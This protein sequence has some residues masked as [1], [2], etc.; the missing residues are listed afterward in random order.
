ME[1]PFKDIKAGEMTQ[2]PN[3]AWP[4]G[5]MRSRE[6]GNPKAVGKLDFNFKVVR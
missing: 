3:Y 2:T 6:A 1:N 5:M 4:R